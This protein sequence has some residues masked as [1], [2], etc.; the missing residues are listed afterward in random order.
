MVMRGNQLRERK[1]TILRKRLGVEAFKFALYVSIPFGC[2][3]Y[4]N[5]EGVQE[6]IRQRVSAAHN[7]RPD[8]V[9][10]FQQRLHDQRK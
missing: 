4:A 7:L 1:M 6:E 8:I 10:Q 3:Y 5:S 9:E 2:L